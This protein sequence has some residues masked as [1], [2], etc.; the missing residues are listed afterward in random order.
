MHELG[1][2]LGL[3]HGGLSRNPDGTFIFEPNCKS[4][5]L[6]VMNY[7]FQVDLLDGNL[8]YAGKPL[9]PLNESTASPSG[10]LGNISQTT[11]W[12]APN[13]PFGSPATSHCDG[14][15][16]TAKD[17]NKNMFRLEGPANSI[18]WSA[19]QDINFDGQIEAS[20]DGYDDWASMDLRQIGATGNDFWAAGGVLS[21][22]TGGGVLSSKTGGGV[23]SSKTGGGVLSSKTGGGVLSSKTGGGVGSEI[24][25]QTA[26]SVVRP[27]KIASGSLRLTASNYVQF[28]FTA[29]TFGQSQIASFNIY[30]SVNSAAPVLYA[31]VP[32]T[33]GTLPTFTYTDQK[34]SCATYSYF[35]TTVLSDGRESVPSNTAGPISVPCTFVG[36]LSP[37]SSASKAPA[38]PTFS[39][40]RNLGNAVPIKW[41][42]LDANGNPIGDLTTLKL[43]QACPT[44]GATSPPG[45][46]FRPPCVLIYTPLQGGEGSTTFRYS[47]PNFIINWDTGSLSGLAP[48][49]WTIELQLSDGRIEWTNLQF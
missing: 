16:I 15:P 37:M 6:S 14:S 12:Y 33:A 28:Q 10:V 42:L 18:T 40:P 21:S 34:V 31:N 3:T 11:K 4:N 36:F 49:Y 39:G 45:S 30:R 24:N 35:V 26:N 19:N 8:D 38:P 7:M 44:T 46:S 43:L 9:N 47:A 27:S 1:H 22:K 5:Y 29:P 41:E 32:V 48:G 20:L 2:S 25:T 17:P 13:Q 23:L